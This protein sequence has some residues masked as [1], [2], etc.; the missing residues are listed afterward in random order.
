MDTN[1]TD[2]TQGSQRRV[3]ISAVILAI[4][5]AGV[6]WYIL[7]GVPKKAGLAPSASPSG[8]P[9]A[10]APEVSG[11]PAITSATPS[12]AATW[13]PALPKATPYVQPSGRT[14]GASAVS[15]RPVSPTSKTGP[16]EWMILLSGLSAAAGSY[17]LSRIIRK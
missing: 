3:I 2:E 14:A 10:A 7:A 16:G 6:L 5:I 15:V 13:N 1:V 17:A 11:W 12:P 8:S 9:L 4:L